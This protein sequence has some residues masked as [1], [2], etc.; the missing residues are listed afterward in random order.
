MSGLPFR[1][2]VAL[3]A[4]ISLAILLAR[5]RPL[6]GSAGV[7][8]VLYVSGLHQPRSLGA[9]PDG[10]VLV[11]EAGWDSP[12]QDPVPG[13]ISRVTERE[14]LAVLVDNLPAAS[15]TQLLFA[16]S[17]PAAVAPAPSAGGAYVLFG[18]SEGAPLGSVARLVRAEGGWHLEDPAVLT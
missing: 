12:D 1:L 13:R 9:M 4:I 7:E 18:A 5:S 8:P 16:Q 3:V 2:T 10:S 17:G 11:A 14:Q 6:G 15:A